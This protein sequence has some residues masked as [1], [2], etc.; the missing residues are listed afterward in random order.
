MKATK[1]KLDI[2][3]L[4]FNRF[5]LLLGFFFHLPVLLFRQWPLFG[6]IVCLSCWRF[7]VLDSEYFSHFP[8]VKNLRRIRNLDISADDDGDADIECG[9]HFN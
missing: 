3:L 7:M 8:R 9:H 4:N 5:F 2:F 6:I 1:R